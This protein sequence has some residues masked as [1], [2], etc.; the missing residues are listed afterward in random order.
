LSIRVKTGNLRRERERKWCLESSVGR[1]GEK[2]LE[3]RNEWLKKTS[4]GVQN[5]RGKCATPI[6][7]SRGKKSSEM[8]KKESPQNTENRLKKVWMEKIEAKT[9][10]FPWGWMVEKKKKGEKKTSR[11]IGGSK[12]N[13]NDK[14]RK[15]KTHSEG[16]GGETAQ[17]G[18]KKKKER[19]MGKTRKK[20]SNKKETVN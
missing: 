15:T 12:K 5:T 3:L 1:D 13:Q 2:S 4:K 19:E 9:G 18:K 11:R 6:S 20:G 7:T 8:F 17:R 14:Q 10:G 16:R